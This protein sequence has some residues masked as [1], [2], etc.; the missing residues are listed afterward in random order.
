MAQY[1]LETDAI[2]LGLT[3]PAMKLGV[4]FSPFFI[5][6]LACLL[7]WMMYQSM[8][9]QAGLGSFTLFAGVGVFSHSVMAY[10]SQKDVFGLSIFMINLIYFRRHATYA[11]WGYTDSFLP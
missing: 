4:P 7:G 6:V 9:G 8:T 2:A 3:Q 5:N 10:L 1:E 11:A